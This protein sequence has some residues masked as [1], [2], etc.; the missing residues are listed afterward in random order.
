MTNQKVPMMS[1]HSQSACILMAQSFQRLQ[2]C[3]YAKKSERL[4]LAGSFRS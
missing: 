1:F 2:N 4:L 3:T